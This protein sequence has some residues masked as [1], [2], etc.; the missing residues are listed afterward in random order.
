MDI[1]VKNL[2]L[3]GA[4]KFCATLMPKSTMIHWDEKSRDLYVIL[5]NND[6]NTVFT[7]E[8][9]DSQEVNGAKSYEYTDGYVCTKEHSILMLMTNHIALTDVCIGRDIDLELEGPIETCPNNSKNKYDL[10][11]STSLY[12][13][14]A[15]RDIGDDVKKGDLGGHVE[16]YHNLSQY[17]DC[18]IYPDAMACDNSRVEGNA[19]IRGHARVLENAMARENCEMTG[20]SILSENAILS[21][22]AKMQDKSKAFGHSRIRGDA[23]MKDEAKA[24]DQVIIRNKA[25]VGQK[26]Y[27]NYGAID[28]DLTNPENIRESILHQTGIFVM[29][30]GN[31]YAYK[32]VLGSDKTTKGKNAYPS[33]QNPNFYYVLDFIAK[34]KNPNPNPLASCSSGLHVSHPMYWNDGSTMLLCKCNINDVLAVQEGKIRLSQLK[35]VGIAEDFRRR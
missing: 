26:Q 34:A 11:P 2:T 21:G 8:F 29:D 19:K 25:V 22:Y 5:E 16:G 27:V 6:E 30:D 17:E 15:L 9:V 20:D 24:E 23:L 3:K 4:L 33:C 1:P 10:V 13:I 14:R 7:A 18:W 12:R 31:F 32:R 28:K 35:V